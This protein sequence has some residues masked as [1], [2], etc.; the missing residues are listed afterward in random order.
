[1]NFLRGFLVNATAMALTMGLGIANQGMLGDGLQEYGDLRWWFF[2]VMLAVQASGEWLGRG[3]LDLVGRMG[4]R[5]LVGGNALAYVG[6]LGVVLSLVVLAFEKPLSAAVPAFPGVLWL[7]VALVVLGVLQK[8]GEAILQGEDRVR[9]YSL[10]PLVFVGTYF[11]GNVVVFHRG[12]GLEQVFYA[13]TAATAAAAAFAWVPAWRGRL[14]FDWS[15]LCRTARVGRR[16]GPA[17]LL[18]SLLMALDVYV[19][20]YL[21]EAGEALRVYGAVTVFAVTFQRPLNVA[22]TVLLPKIVRGA[23]KELLSA[24]VAQGAL[25]LGLI[26]AGVLVIGGRWAISLVYDTPVFAA[27]Y[28]PLMWLLPG[29]VAIGFASV[30]NTRLYSQGYP[31]V[32]IWAPAVAVLAKLALNAL[33][34][35]A[36]PAWGLK[37]VALAASL[38]HALW[39]AI[40]CL[41]YLHLAG[42]GPRDL[43]RPFW[44]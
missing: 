24:K 31:A 43:T 8:A 34:F 16:G 17:F 1:M 30:L 13:W 4:E 32:T 20:E 22:G 2:S 18:V 42:V 14:G 29:L 11:V 27:A 39:A 10:V 40:V 9:H 37:G 23:D 25:I 7:A 36:Y 38:A 41:Y 19:V 3:S 15:L 28:E 12:G 5:R 44:R 33:F 35:L 6:V 26:Q 21:W